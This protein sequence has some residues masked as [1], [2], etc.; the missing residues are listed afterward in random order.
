MVQAAEMET[1]AKV[2]ARGRTYARQGQVIDVQCEPGMFTARIQ[3]TSSQPYL[4]RLDR[5]TISGSERVSA[6]CDCPYGC[7]FGWCKHAAALAYVAAFL[8]DVDDEV[9]SRWAGETAETT[10]AVAALTEEE[11]AWLGAPPPSIDARELLSRAEAIVPY[12]HKGD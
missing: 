2:L 8:M 1:D 9:R 6:D 7:D 12:P 5:V 3:G 11:L 10:V 4:V